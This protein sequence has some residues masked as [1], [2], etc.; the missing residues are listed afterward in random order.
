MRKKLQK[1]PPCFKCIAYEHKGE[2]I[3]FSLQKQFGV[4]RE[5]DKSLISQ[6]Q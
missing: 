1:N 6:Q 4:L 5:E 3:L 2:N